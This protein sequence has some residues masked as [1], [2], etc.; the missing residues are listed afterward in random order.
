M[1][2]K[3]S[4]NTFV[5]VASLLFLTVIEG[6]AQQLPQFSQYMFNSLH[7]NPGYAGYKD[8]GYIQG[9]YRNQWVNFPG[10]PKTIA[11]SADFS[12]NEGQTGI[13]VSVMNDKIGASDNKIA[14][15]TYARRVQLSRKSFVGLGMSSGVSQYKLD[16]SMLKMN[17]LNDAILPNGMIN[18]TVPNLNIGF[19]YHNSDFYLGFSTFNVIG[20]SLL[21]TRD[22]VFIQHDRHHFLTGGALF[23]MNQSIQFK[24]SFLVKQTEGSPTSVDLNAM[25]SLNDKV[26]VGGSY[27][28][29]VR[30]FEV[31]LQ[32]RKELNEHTALVGLVEVFL[33][34]D[35]RLGYSF[36][37][38]LN[39]LN[40]FRAS[41]H[42]LSIGIYF[43][44][45]VSENN[46]QRCF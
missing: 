44:R 20:K 8:A 29:N 35:L 42:E 32:N 2:M 7:I 3:N 18:K 17:D 39:V 9:T 26:W 11:F 46:S 27:R 13:G 16:G 6:L 5:L 15:I 43:R 12:A 10:A 1:M 14:L 22:V 23:R 4:I 31:L 37:H 45:F 30:P 36:D 38:N 41:S 24:P 28:T 25:F 19:F 33:T 34:P 40:N 21:K